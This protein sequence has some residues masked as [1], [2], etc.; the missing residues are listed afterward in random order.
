MF[1]EHLGWD[2]TEENIAITAG[3]QTAFF[4]LFN[5]LAGMNSEGVRKK[6]VLPLVPE[7]I[8]YANQSV[9]ED[10]FV[11]FPPKIEKNW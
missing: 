5:A 6:I 3:G 11:A 7:Y 10:F 9:G 4:F 1:R 2:V 8:G